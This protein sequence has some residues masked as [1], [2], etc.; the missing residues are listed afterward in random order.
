MNLNK[1]LMLVQGFSVMQTKLRVTALRTGRFPGR[2]EGDLEWIPEDNSLK[3]QLG[4][5]EQQGN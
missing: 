4:E 1:V 3:T 5:S 2:K